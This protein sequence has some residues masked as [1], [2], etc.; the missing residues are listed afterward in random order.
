[1]SPSLY[2]LAASLRS[3]NSSA[4]IVSQDR[5]TSSAKV[6][7]NHSR[8]APRLKRFW[9]SATGRWMFLARGVREDLTCR[10]TG[11]FRFIGRTLGQPG[12][13]SVTAMDSEPSFAF[14]FP[15]PESVQNSPHDHP[16]AS[17]P[18]V[19]PLSGVNPFAVKVE[20]YFVRSTASASEILTNIAVQDM[21]ATDD[22]GLYDLSCHPRSTSTLSSVGLSDFVYPLAS[23]ESSDSDS[24]LGNES[25]QR[26]PE[27]SP[28]PSD[29]HDAGSFPPVQI[30]KTVRVI[31]ST[32][33][34]IT[35][36]ITYRD[37][38]PGEENADDE[39]VIVIPALPRKSSSI[40][41]PHLLSPIPE[42]DEDETSSVETV[43]ASIPTCARPDTGL[44]CA[45]DGVEHLCESSACIGSDRRMSI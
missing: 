21:L 41:H 27:V 4:T 28:D 39:E 22:P 23:S 11:A 15:D 38:P 26:S 3:N 32:E 5:A 10:I 7:V 24:E 45:S 14:L 1:M 42:E 36:R 33:V 31:S 34:E 40:P 19:E 30:N 17:H 12:K 43:R 8:L 25:P 35:F 18:A 16:P 9:G 2:V 44:V 20:P 29:R 6:S 37:S 13:A